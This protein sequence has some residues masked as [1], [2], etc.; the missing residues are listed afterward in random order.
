MKADTCMTAE[1][2]QVCPTFFSPTGHCKK[3]LVR[4]FADSSRRLS[5]AELKKSEGSF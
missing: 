3:M 4:D 5:Q 1:N 2:Q